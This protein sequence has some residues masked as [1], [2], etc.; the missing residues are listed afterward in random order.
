MPSPALEPGRLVALDAE[1]LIAADQ[2]CGSCG[3]LLRAQPPDGACPECGTAVADTLNA[4]NIRL[5]P[6]DWLRRIQAGSVCLAIS[7]PLIWLFGLGV[8][9]WLLGVLTMTVEVPKSRPEF[10]RLQRVIGGSGVLAVIASLMLF[11]FEGYGGSELLIFAHLGMVALCLGVHI[12]SVLRYAARVCDAADWGTQK[13]FGNVLAVFGFL[14]PGLAVASLIL[15]GISFNYAWGGTAPPW[16][17]PLL[18]AVGIPAFFGG[19]AFAFAQ[20]LYW[21]AIATRMHRIRKEARVLYDEAKAFAANPPP[22]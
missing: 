18:M 7:I 13:N 17:D 5:L 8:L 4:S 14:W 10:K 9:V 19:I 2:P 15:L 20:F 12:G 21:I 22:V 6:L 1:G 16:L 11:A 3:Y